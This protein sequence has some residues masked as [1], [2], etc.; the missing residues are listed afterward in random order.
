MESQS[1]LCVCFKLH[2]YSGPSLFVGLAFYV[3]FPWKSASLGGP[4]T[5]P[6]LEIEILCGPS[7]S[8]KVSHGFLHF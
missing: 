7:A 5:D 6:R 2:K 3:A 4:G 1:V 8:H